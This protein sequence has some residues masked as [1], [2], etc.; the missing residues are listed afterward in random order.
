[1]PFIINFNHLKNL[2]SHK[3]HSEVYHA[4]AKNFKDCYV[5]E[6]L[7]NK[8]H[9][10]TMQLFIEWLW[11]KLQRKIWITVSTLDEFCKGKFDKNRILFVSFL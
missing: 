7:L 10:L 8:D 1:M 9:P 5:E 6:N 2:Q 3:M 4:K 11:D